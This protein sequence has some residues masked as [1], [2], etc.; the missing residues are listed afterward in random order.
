MFRYHLSISSEAPHANEHV[1]S[2]E[3]CDSGNQTVNEVERT[4]GVE[5]A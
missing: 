4:G 2:G 5:R 3:A 1:K